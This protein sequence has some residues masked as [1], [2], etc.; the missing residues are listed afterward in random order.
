MYRLNVRTMTCGGCGAAITR[1]ISA[2]D[3]SARV[4]TFP[5]IHRVDVETSL[6]L[7]E[8][9]QVFNNAGYPAD[10]IGSSENE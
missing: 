8:L 6:S 7:E 1:A 5:S 9:L 2:A 4:A 3:P 10:P